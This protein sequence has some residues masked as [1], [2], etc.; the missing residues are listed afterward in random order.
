[1]GVPLQDL[2]PAPRHALSPYD[3]LDRQ[4]PRALREASTGTALPTLSCAGSKFRRV[5]RVRQMATLT[6]A[7]SS[8][9]HDPPSKPVRQVG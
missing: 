6:D 4:I 2:P 8:A 7:V 9:R 5:R 1:M 3:A